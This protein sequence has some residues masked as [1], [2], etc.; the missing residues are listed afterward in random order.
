MTDAHLRK[1]KAEGRTATARV[2]TQALAAGRSAFTILE[3][4]VSMTVLSLI[5]VLLLTVNNQTMQLWRR[6]SGS[7][8]AFQA[9]RLGFDVMIRQLKSATLNVYWDYDPP[10][11]DNPTRYV[12]RSDLAFVCGP[13]ATLL[14]ATYGPGQCVFFQTPAGRMNDPAARRLKLVLNT[15][16]FFISYGDVNQAFPGFLSTPARNR[17]RLMSVQSTGEEM[18][19]FTGRTQNTW[20]TGQ[21]GNARTVAENVVLLVVRPLDA[22]RVDLGYT[23]DTRLGESTKPQ[24]ATSNQL[25]PLLDVTMVVVTEDSENRKNSTAGYQFSAADLSGLFTNPASYDQ[26]M[27]AFQAVLAR[28]KLDYRVFRQQV[29]LPNSKWS[30]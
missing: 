21:L 8:D 10:F 14:G 20:F 3:M 4:L 6:S 11:P 28:E 7:V 12:R 9:A 17:Y 5:L 27:T 26:D 2:W 1:L 19:L 30:D 15:C 18:S 23:L 13:A 29:S 24:P 25:P 16:G 22:A